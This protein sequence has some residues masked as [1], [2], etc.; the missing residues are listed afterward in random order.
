MAGAAIGLIRLRGRPIVWLFA[1][2][3]AL[4]ASLLAAAL[5]TQGRTSVYPML[6]A[7]F[8]G[9]IGSAAYNICQTTIV[10]ESTAASIKK[11]RGGMGLVRAF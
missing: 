10:V 5:A 9:G 11:F 6:I 7:F 2:S 4:S 8:L 3:L 1:G